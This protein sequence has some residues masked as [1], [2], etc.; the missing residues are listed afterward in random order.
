MN[1]NQAAFALELPE[2]INRVLLARSEHNRTMSGSSVSIKLEKVS[3][4]FVFDGSRS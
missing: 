1:M 4:S 2:V 3:L